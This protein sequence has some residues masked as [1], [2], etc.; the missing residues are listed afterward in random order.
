M[1]QKEL[2][3]I[4]KEH[5]LWLASNGEKGKCAVLKG[6]DL[7]GVDLSGA[8]LRQANL[9]FT[10]LRRANLTCANLR[11]ADLHR[12]DLRKAILGCTEMESTNLEGAVLD[13][14]E[15]NRKGIILVKKMIGY[16]KCRDDVIVK[17]EIPK[18]AV[19]FSINNYTCR[20]NIAK[21][22]DIIGAKE[23]VSLCYSWFVYRKGETLKIDDFDLMY[24]IECST[25][26]HFF[27]T[28]KEA[29]EYCL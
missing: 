2:N 25:G 3:K 16:K 19:V 8:D 28:E 26:I 21:V 10:N 29:R 6:A 13:E 1:T 11:Q 12:A 15:K 23:G 7:R 14:T 27:R 20:T 4:L 22:I 24:N 18:G 5:S 9:A 17:L